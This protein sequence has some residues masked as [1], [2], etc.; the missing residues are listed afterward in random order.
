[1]PEPLDADGAF[2]CATCGHEWVDE[3]PAA[4][5]DVNG[6]VLTDGD[7]ITIVK[8]L[9]LDGKAGGIKV[10]TKVKGIRLIAG[11]HPIQGRVGGRTVLIMAD[12]VRKA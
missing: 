4:V 11:D 3:R 5:T 10:G 7:D 2:E 1:M 12:K 6:N 9:K 8:D